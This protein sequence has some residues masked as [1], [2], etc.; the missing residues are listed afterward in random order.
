MPP[1]IPIFPA[2]HNP[3][4][5]RMAA[6]R[7]ERRRALGPIQAE[8]CRIG[9]TSAPGLAAKPIIE[10][11][12]LAASSADLDRRRL[13]VE[14][15]GYEWR[16]G[17]EMAGRRR[18]A[19]AEES[20]VRTVHLH[21]FMEDSPQ[22]RRHIAFRDCW[23]ANPAAAIAYENEKPRAQKLHPDSSDACSD[24][25]AAWIWGAE[26]KALVWF[27]AQRPQ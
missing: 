3:D 23:R 14:A 12:P 11:M 4:W 5:P 6:H 22:V 20:G 10:D 15:L 27:A 26:P 24:E 19:L 13:Q 8:V 2:P 21:F 7:A 9:S 25:K 1:P 16:E 17:L 18:R